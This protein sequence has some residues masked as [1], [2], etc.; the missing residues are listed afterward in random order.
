MELTLHTGELILF[1]G[2]S[3]T[4]AFRKPDE[5]GTSYQMGAGYAMLIA[6]KLQAERPELLLRYENRGICG[7]R[8]REMALRW[9]QDCLDLRPDIVSILIGVVD[10]LRTMEDG[11]GAPLDDFERTYRRLL[12]RTQD[13]L[14]DIRLVLVEPFL[15]PC[16]TI[17]PAHLAD[18]RL[19][20]RAIQRIA[21]DYGVIFVPL[22]AALEA[23]A[24]ETGPEY[25][26][27]DGIHPNA[28]A[29]WLIARE[30]LSATGLLGDLA[31]D[32][33]S[34]VMSSR[35]SLS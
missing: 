20:Q 12:A 6:A 13:E 19:R 9:Q 7:D 25:W 21:E 5:I 8:L 2:D 11:S 32:L 4:H 14:P 26:L 30:W 1:Q 28:P 27:F 33:P 10:T 24:A 3:I 17:T 35:I 34:G 31:F 16:G 22:Q 23:A 15:L 18:L 29:Q